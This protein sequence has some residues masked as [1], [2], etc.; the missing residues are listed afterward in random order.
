MMERTDE[1]A[2]AAPCA[3][4]RRRV[5][6]LAVGHVFLLIDIYTRVLYFIIV[7]RQFFKVDEWIEI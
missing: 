4:F 6:Y 3:R 5:V 7:I 1:L 2:Y